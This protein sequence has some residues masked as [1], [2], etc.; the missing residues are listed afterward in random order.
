MDK[1]LGMEFN[2][3]KNSV[4]GL[5]KEAEAEAERE[6]AETERDRERE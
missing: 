6:E 2:N 3:Y 1:L 4:P 5:V